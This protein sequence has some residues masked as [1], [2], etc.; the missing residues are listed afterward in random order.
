MKKSCNKCPHEIIKAPFGPICHIT[1]KSAV[2][3]ENN[4]DLKLC[5]I[6]KESNQNE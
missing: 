3:I 1:G 2:Y 4:K 5:P 6:E